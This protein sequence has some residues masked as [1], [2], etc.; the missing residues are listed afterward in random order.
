[1]FVQEKPKNFFRFVELFHPT[2]EQWQEFFD[3]LERERQQHGIFFNPKDYEI[4]DG[5]LPF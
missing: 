1:M 4:P 3:M 5:E 2:Q